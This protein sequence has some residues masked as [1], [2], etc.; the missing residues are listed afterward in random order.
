MTIQLQTYNSDYNSNIDIDLFDDEKS[1]RL[2]FKQNINSLF[3]NFVLF[4][5][6]LKAL[7][8]DQNIS[9]VNLMLCEKLSATKMIEVD[10]EN[11]KLNFNKS[12]IKNILDN[13]EFNS[14]GNN[15]EELYIKIITKI[16]LCDNIIKNQFDPPR[17]KTRL[18]SVASKKLPSRPPVKSS[19]TTTSIV[20]TNVEKDNPK[21]VEKDN[22]KA[23]VEK[24][25]PKIVEKKIVKKKI[26]TNFFLEIG[27][28][29][30]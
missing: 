10:V 29:H 13:Y 15:E 6:N 16:L 21:I 5:K 20:K 8:N 27:R 26:R 2:K 28:A 23:N 24:D 18:P 7:Q 30:V 3:P 25:N 22:V 17:K 4:T 1:L 11:K 19:T 9:I 12:I 14:I